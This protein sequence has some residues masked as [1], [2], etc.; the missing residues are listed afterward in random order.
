MFQHEEK[1]SRIDLHSTI[2]T[3]TKFFWIC[4]SFLF[5][6]VFFTVSHYEKEN[7]SRGKQEE[8]FKATFKIGSAN[9][10]TPIKFL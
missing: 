9:T 6:S 5:T 7:W 10:P 3:K 4:S 1:E 8:L 2:F